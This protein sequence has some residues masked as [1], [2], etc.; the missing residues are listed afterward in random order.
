MEQLQR[1]QV[2]FGG[3]L[4]YLINETCQMNTWVG[5]IACWQASMASFAQFP[6][7]ECPAASL[8]EDD[9]DDEDDEDSVSSSSDDEM[10]TS[11]W[12]TLCH[13]WQKGGVVLVLRVVLYLGGELV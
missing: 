13:S 11:Q 9:D 2:N 4:N 12:L 6:S 8:S 10:T 5:R 3:H 1:M 7:L